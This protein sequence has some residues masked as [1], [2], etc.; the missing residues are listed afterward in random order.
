MPEGLNE[1]DHLAVVKH[2]NR[3]AQIRQMTDAALGEVGVVHQKHV[4]RPHGG[5]RKI[6]HD[7]VWH[8]GIRTTGQLAAMTVEQADA[9][10]MRFTDHGAARRALD[11]VLDLGFD[12]IQRAFDD[13]QHDRIDRRRRRGPGQ[14]R[15][16]Q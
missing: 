16:R 3:A 5:D 1:R 10:I 7:R 11:R 4:A 14:A 12:G 9:V 2:R 8:R 15:L 6:A 13:L